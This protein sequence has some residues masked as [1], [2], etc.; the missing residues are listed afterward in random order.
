MIILR[1]FTVEVFHE[2]LSVK[3]MFLGQSGHVILCKVMLTN[4]HIF[5]TQVYLT[6]NTSPEM[7]QLFRILLSYPPLLSPTLL[8]VNL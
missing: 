3:R 8:L 4:A 2:Y 7:V 5:I 6:V 1:H